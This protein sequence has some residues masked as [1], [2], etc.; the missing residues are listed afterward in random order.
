VGEDERDLFVRRIRVER[1]DDIL[2]ALRLAMGQ[3]AAAP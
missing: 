3:V 1:Q 2:A